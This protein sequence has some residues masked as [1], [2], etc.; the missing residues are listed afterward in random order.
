MSVNL[1]DALDALAAHASVCDVCLEYTAT[2]YGS[3]D[4]V[5][6]RHS[7]THVARCSQCGRRNPLSATEC[8]APCSAGSW[9]LTVQPR[10]LCDL[11]HAAALRAANARRS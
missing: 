5:C 1:D 3:G 11:P 7:C 6:D 8:E 9:A 10:T 4:Y 2:Q